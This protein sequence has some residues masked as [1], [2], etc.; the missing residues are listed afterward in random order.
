MS[1]QKKKRKQQ[2]K[3]TCIGDEAV[4]VTLSKVWEDKKVCD[5]INENKAL[6]DQIK[7]VEKA[8]EKTC[9]YAEELVSFARK[10]EPELHQARVKK[11]YPKELKALQKDET[12]WQDGFNSACL[13]TSRLVCETLDVEETAECLNYHPNPKDETAIIPAEQIRQQIIEDF[14]SLDT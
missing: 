8:L 2:E 3:N 11:M 14:P 4:L 5:L 12:N 9:G 10:E 6:H 13:A 1:T 7:F